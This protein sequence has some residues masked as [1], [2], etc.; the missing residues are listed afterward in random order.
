[1]SMRWGKGML[2]TAISGSGMVAMLAALAFLFIGSPARAALEDILY[3]KGHLT[4]EEWIKAKAGREKEDAEKDK[5]MQGAM[6]GAVTHDQKKQWIDSVIWSGDLRLRHEQFW[7][8]QPSTTGA[9]GLG[10]DRSRQRFRLR[11]GPEIKM[12]DFKVVIQA[13]TSSSTDGI[14]GD[15]V[16]HNQSF[17][18]AFSQKEFFIEQAYASWNPSFFTPMTIMGGKLKNPFYT[19]YTNDVLFDSDVNPEGLAQQFKWT[20]TDS[21]SL[22]ANFG[23]FILDEDSTDNNDQFMLAY[24]GG[25]ELKAGVHKL[26]VA[27]G[28]FDSLNLSHGGISEPTV[29]QFNS[30]VAVAPTSTTAYVN[31]YNVFHAT[32]RLDSEIIGIPAQVS[33]DYLRNTTGVISC[34]NNAGNVPGRCGGTRIEDQN[35]GYQVGLL[36]GKAGKANTFEAGY[37]YKWLQ[38]DATLSAFVDSDFGDGGT[39]RRGNIFWIGYSPTD[40]LNFKFKFFNTKPLQTSL[41]I[42]STSVPS[43][44]D[45]IN[46][47]QI[48]AVLTF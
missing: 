7:R 33:G 45:D 5:Q 27:L 18:N 48:D 35:E 31:D 25:A 20:A 9:P 38:A 34:A 29:Q 28:Y 14:N 19:Q 8:E 37:Y 43:C 39:N 16:S 46:R 2:R 4:K 11:F 44:R 47:M 15:Q 6:K 12:K 30:R 32:G 1:M 21:V 41:C 23:Q 17:D 10:A 26:R 40:F 42:G 3:E 13:G 22:F 24:Q 36:I